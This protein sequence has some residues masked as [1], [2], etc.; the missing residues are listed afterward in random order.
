MAEV[1]R[2]CPPDDLMCRVAKEMGQNSRL[3]SRRMGQVGE[4]QYQKRVRVTSGL[5]MMVPC[6]SPVMASAAWRSRGCWMCEEV[7]DDGLMG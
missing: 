4:A 1:A 6:V 7:C 2:R 3:G 5:A